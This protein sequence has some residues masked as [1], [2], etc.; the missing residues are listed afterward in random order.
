MQVSEMHGVGGDNTFGPTFQ[1][2]IY[3]YL[4]KF[5]ERKKI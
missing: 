5:H 4:T 1:D 2:N 3:C